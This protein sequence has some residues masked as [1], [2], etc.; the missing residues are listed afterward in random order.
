LFSISPQTPKGAGFWQPD[1]SL[2]SN[3]DAEWR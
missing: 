2:M 3:S 1:C